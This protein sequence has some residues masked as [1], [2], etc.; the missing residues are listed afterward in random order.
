MFYPES[1]PIQAN[2]SQIVHLLSFFGI[3]AKILYSLML[4]ILQ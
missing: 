3:L 1:P 2:N 4:T